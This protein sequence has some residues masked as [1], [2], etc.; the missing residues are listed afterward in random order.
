MDLLYP[1]YHNPYKS[2]NQTPLLKDSNYFGVCHF[3]KK[4]KKAKK[5]KANFSERA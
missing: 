5:K 1:H 2:A 4:T 3:Q